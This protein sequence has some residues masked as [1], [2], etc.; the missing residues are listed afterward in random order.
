MCARLADVVSERARRDCLIGVAMTSE[1]AIR[2]TLAG[3]PAGEFS[4]EAC[5]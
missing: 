2:T 5:R 4:T 1:P 3:V